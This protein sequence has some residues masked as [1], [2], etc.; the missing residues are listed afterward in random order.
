MT[1]F[2]GLIAR[3]SRAIKEKK[4]KGLPP[5]RS[6]S[7]GCSHHLTIKEKRVKGLAPFHF[8][9]I[10]GLGLF[11]LNF[12][13]TTPIT[14]DIPVYNA[15]NTQL[16]QTLK[17]EDTPEIPLQYQ[18]FEI[19]HVHAQDIQNA[20][21]PL[22]PELKF[23]TFSQSLMA[24]GHPSDLG[25]LRKMLQKIDQP[26]RQIHIQID[27]IE[28]HDGHN[29]LSQLW[30]PEFNQGLQIGTGQTPSL[31][32]QSLLTSGKAKLLANPSL[33]VMDKKTAVITVGD[34]IPYSTTVYSNGIAAQQ[35]QQ[36]DTGISIE[37]SPRIVSENHVEALLSTKINRVKPGTTVQAHPIL[38]S[39]HAA[40]S[41]SMQENT[42]ITIAGLLDQQVITTKTAV[43]IL[44]EI[45]LIGDL[46]HSSSAETVTTDIVLRITSRILP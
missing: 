45:P 30:S 31:T 38:A 12:G 3:Q 9:M 24:H 15:F 44:S 4:R 43:P 7:A 27:V 25:K 6:R 11:A 17:Q 32:L 34:K 26:I 35:I 10:L 2:M 40:T 23:S 41:I 5:F 22:F 28:I 8:P 39:R 16:L 19:H 20:V 1:I 46:F 36:V 29:Q 13:I 21:T 37:I 33:T 14:A 18:V 42:P